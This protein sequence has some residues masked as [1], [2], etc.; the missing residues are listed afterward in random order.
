M[1][2]PLDTIVHEMVSVVV[3]MVCIDIM[4]LLYGSLTGR[5][6]LDVLCSI[7][8]IWCG[9][10]RLLSSII[11]GVLLIC[12]LMEATDSSSVSG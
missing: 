10:S 4:S 2:S 3:A 9:L 8:L 7:L 11:A 12:A 5:S 6:L 1:L